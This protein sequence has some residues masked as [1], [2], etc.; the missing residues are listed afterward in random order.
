MATQFPNISKW[1]MNPTIDNELSNTLWTNPTITDAQKTNILKFRIGQYMGNARKQ[2]FFG[3]ERF[4]SI[5][6]SI[7]NSEDA[8]TWLH[9]L[10]KCN[11]HHIHAIRVKRHNK[12]VWILRKPI[13]SSKKSW[14]Y[15]LMNAGTFNDNP[16]ERTIHPWLLACTCKQQRY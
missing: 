9:V 14:C 8:D 3:R 5:T 7:C 6:Y 4:S 1:T 15:T 10:Q 2:L 12:T 16:Q 11:H 13:M